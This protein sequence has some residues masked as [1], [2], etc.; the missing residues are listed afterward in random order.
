MDDPF[1]T[2]IGT[3]FFLFGFPISLITAIIMLIVHAVRM[4][5]IRLL[6]NYAVSHPDM[7]VD[8]IIKTLVVH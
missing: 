5:P 7:D 1:V 3:A 8:D 2:G 4:R 6:V